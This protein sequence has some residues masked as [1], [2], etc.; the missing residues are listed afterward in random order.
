MIV[1]NWYLVVAAAVFLSGLL[2]VLINRSNAIAILISVELM[3]LGA[4]LNFIIFAY[5]GGGVDGWVF[6]LFALAIAAAEA[7]VGLA[8]ITA[9]F[10]LTGSIKMQSMKNLGDK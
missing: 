3:L 6:S 10:R 9:F 5:Y 1:A 7:V 8:I 4:N 2:G